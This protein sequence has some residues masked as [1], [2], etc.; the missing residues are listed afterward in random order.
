MIYSLD[1][2]PA[3][4]KIP[5][6]SEWGRSALETTLDE[7]SSVYIDDINNLSRKYH[8]RGRLNP[9]DVYDNKW[10][11][12]LSGPIQQVVL[13]SYPY[14][15]KPNSID[16]EWLCCYSL[17]QE[18]LSPAIT[19]RIT[20]GAEMRKPGPIITRGT[21][22]ALIVKRR[23]HELILR[24]FHI[25][26]TN[27]IS[28]RTLG[29]VINEVETNTN[30]VIK[31]EWLG[32][33]PGRLVDKPKVR[34]ISAV[35]DMAVGDMAVGDMA[36]GSV[37]TMNTTTSDIIKGGND[38]PLDH[39]SKWND[40]AKWI[41]GADPTGQISLT[42]MR[43]W[44]NLI[45]IRMKTADIIV[46]INVLDDDRPSAIAFALMNIAPSGVVI[47]NV[48]KISTTATAAMIHLFSH[49]FEKTFIH[50][51]KALD[52][53]FL[54]GVGFLNNLTNTHHKL[55]YE[56]CEFYTD[57]ANTTPFTYNYVNSEPFVKTLSILTGIKNKIQ[58]WRYN[59]YERL[60]AIHEKLRV[61]TSAKLF[62]DYVD[63][64]LNEE[65]KKDQIP[66]FSY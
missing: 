37:T 19:E 50:H 21:V 28:V 10:N 65:Y 57:A 41:T 27:A 1:I 14:D 58:D 4:K 23:I 15:K 13:A 33:R 9:S 24:S 60:L 29:K 35:G 7:Q 49:C 6:R 66:T 17:Y 51:T 44:R 63:T 38:T 31:W 8:V 47:L 20:A 48:G 30:S 18:V 11:V 34:R 62:E 43:S 42:N 36:V 46:E 16:A 55:L 3:V 25:H 52:R 39:D 59:Y 45:L 64:V 26:D 61:S 5:D 53:V 32:Q 2:T 54:C 40:P 22:E 12:L 56:F